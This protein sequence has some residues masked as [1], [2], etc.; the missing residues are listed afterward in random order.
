[1]MGIMEAINRKIGKRECNVSGFWNSVTLAM[2]RGMQSQNFTTDW[3]EGW[4]KNRSKQRG[5]E[6]SK[7]ATMKCSPLNDV[8]WQVLMLQNS[9]E[10]HWHTFH[11]KVESD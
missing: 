11:Q 6:R 5:K 8:N 1:M 9:A 2:R 3:N 7:R 10:E 4:L